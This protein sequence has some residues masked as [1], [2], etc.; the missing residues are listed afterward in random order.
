[1]GEQAF[2]WVCGDPWSGTWLRELAAQRGDRVSIRES[3]DQLHNL[4]VQGPNS[5]AL[6]SE[7]VWQPENRTPVSELKWFHFTIGRLGG[8]EGIPLMVSRTGYTGE[9]GFEVWCHPDDGAAVWDVIWQ[10]GPPL[11]HSP[12]LR[13]WRPL[14]VL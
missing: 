4:A 1:M 11:R 10:A 9:L 14:H 2:R 8:P 13:H 12:P 3:T 5:R 7:L 6:L